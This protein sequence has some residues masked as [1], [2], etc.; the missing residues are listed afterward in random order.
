MFSDLRREWERVERGILRAQA[1]HSD[2]PKNQSGIRWLLGHIF[3][4]GLLNSLNLI[5]PSVKW[6]NNNAYLVGVDILSQFT[7]SSWHS[8]NT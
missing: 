8:I 5:S 3:L 2:R 7:L 1:L 4:G 6:D